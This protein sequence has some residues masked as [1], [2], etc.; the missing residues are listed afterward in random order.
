MKEGE[1]KYCKNLSVIVGFVDFC[2]FVLRGQNF[3]LS[4]RGKSNAIFRFFF[5][6]CPLRG[7]NGWAVGQSMV[8]DY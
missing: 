4:S 6:C 5:F 8:D 3:F 7:G 1:S 2:V